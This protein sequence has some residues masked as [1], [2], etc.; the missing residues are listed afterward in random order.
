MNDNMDF[1]LRIPLIPKLRPDHNTKKW[2]EKCNI[3]NKE[4]GGTYNLIQKP[5]FSESICF[6]FNH[7]TIQ[8]VCVLK[9]GSIFLDGIKYKKSYEIP[10]LHTFAFSGFFKPTL[11][12]VYLQ[13]P[14]NFNENKKFLISTN[15]IST[16][17]SI[18][19]QGDYHVAITMVWIE[20]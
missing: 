16:D 18:C 15:L 14:G 12:E 1:G 10:T 9:D 17:P 2:Y 4:D 11:P 13:M 20:E 3:L 5:L 7:K 19:V 6:T 8:E